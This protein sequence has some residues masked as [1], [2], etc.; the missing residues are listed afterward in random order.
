MRDAESEQEFNPKTVST[1]LTVFFCHVSLRNVHVN[2]DYA[3]NVRTSDSCGEN[4]SR[5]PSPAF[6]VRS[7]ILLIKAAKKGTSAR[8]VFV[9]LTRFLAHLG[10]RHIVG[11]LAEEMEL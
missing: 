9:S 11:T 1:C 2:I 10:L 7:G 4:L 5:M 3:V 8:N 6:T